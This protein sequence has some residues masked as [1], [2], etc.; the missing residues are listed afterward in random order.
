MRL[1]YITILPFDIRCPAACWNAATTLT[2]T[3]RRLLKQTEFLKPRGEPLGQGIYA[4]DCVTCN[5][6]SKR[7]FLNFSTD[8]ICSCCFGISMNTI[9][10]PDHE[11]LK[12]IQKAMGGFN[13]RIILIS[14]ISCRSLRRNVKRIFLNHLL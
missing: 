6:Y 9:N 1:Y 4:V 10:N 8:V 12:N 5:L 3:W 14:I 11:L 13:Y 7:L 2:N